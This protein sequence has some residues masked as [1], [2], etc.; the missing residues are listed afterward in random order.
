MAAAMS[1]SL[2]DIWFMT[3]VTDASMTA[4]CRDE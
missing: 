2:G 3:C 1:T 4:S